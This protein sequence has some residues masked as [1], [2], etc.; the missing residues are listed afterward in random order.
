MSEQCPVI[1]RWIGRCWYGRWRPQC[2]Q[3]P[4]DRISV[5]S[6]KRHRRCSL[7]GCM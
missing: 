3:R 2:Q 1:R 5:R 6:G 4:Q 7:F